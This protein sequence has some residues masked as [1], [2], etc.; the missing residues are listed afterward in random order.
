V[1]EQVL[2]IQYLAATAASVEAEAE[3][4][5]REQVPQMVLEADLRSMLERLLK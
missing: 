2:V 4:L 1:G 5:D 3:H